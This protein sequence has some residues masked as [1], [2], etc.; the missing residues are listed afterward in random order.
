MIGLLARVAVP[1]RRAGSGCAG[2]TLI[3][4]LVVIA[5]IAVLIGL[6]LPAVQKVREAA[7]RMQGHH[8]L[9]EL[10]QDLTDFADKRV[11]ATQNHIWG[12]V[13]SLSSAASD[14]TGRTDPKIDPTLL[15]ALRQDIAD[16]EADNQALLDDVRHRLGARH[17]RDRHRELLLEAESALKQSLDG[18]QKI[19]RAIPP[20]PT[21]A[22]G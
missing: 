6:L 3:E 13:A 7:A 2:F 4:L 5:I 11:P 1:R 22:P 8:D 12:I 10:A 15:D 18:L 19:K 14:P 21:P 16:R 20:A 17:L 9:R